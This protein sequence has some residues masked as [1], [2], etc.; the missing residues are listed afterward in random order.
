M[1]GGWSLFELE[2]GEC[3]KFFGPT[4]TAC[5]DQVRHVTEYHVGQMDRAWCYE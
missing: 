4:V 2:K 1:E 5:F 3:L